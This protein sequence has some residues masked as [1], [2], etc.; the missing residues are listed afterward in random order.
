MKA[1]G[2]ILLLAVAARLN[3]TVR[4]GGLV[5]TVPVLFLVAAAEVLALAGIVGLTVRQCRPRPRP[6]GT[7]RHARIRHGGSYA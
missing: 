4:A 7:G 3:V 2:L 6:A 1:A 5:L